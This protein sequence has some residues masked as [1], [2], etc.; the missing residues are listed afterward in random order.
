MTFFEYMKQNYYGKEGRKAHLANDMAGDEAEFPT[1]IGI[2]DR[3]GYG[4]I[5]RYLKSCHACRACLRVFKECWK[6]YE[7]CER[8]R[9]NRNW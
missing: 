9:S 1:Y 3:D 6:E 8:S 5:R 7:E 2:Y 4:V